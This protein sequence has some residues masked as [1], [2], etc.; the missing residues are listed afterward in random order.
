[1]ATRPD[2][3]SLPP[4]PPPPP[5]HVHTEFLRR[6]RSLSGR[7]KCNA[8]AQVTASG[9]NSRAK[10]PALAVGSAGADAPPKPSGVVERRRRKTGEASAMPTYK[11]KKCLE[12]FQKVWRGCL[13]WNCFFFKILAEITHRTNE[14]GYQYHIYQQDHDRGERKRMV[15]CYSILSAATWLPI[16]GCFI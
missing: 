10:S 8:F 16:F 1:M 13:L 6:R 12:C 3:L 15:A 11:K 5:P 4:P 14:D 2:L 9:V 7:G